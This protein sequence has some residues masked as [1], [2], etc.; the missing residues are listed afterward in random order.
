MPIDRSDKRIEADLELTAK[1]LITWR[2]TNWEKIRPLAIAA[3]GGKRRPL[4]Q[5]PQAGKS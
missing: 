1:L 3:A 4:R 2:T 5:R